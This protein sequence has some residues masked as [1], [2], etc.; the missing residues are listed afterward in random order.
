MD[1]GRPVKVIA[2]TNVLVRH[3]I[4]DDPDQAAVATA[5]LGEAQTVALPLVT[6]CEL[7]WVLRRAYKVPAP[8]VSIA[9]RAL[10]NASNVEADRAGVDAGLALLDAGGDFADGVIAYAGR[11]LGGDRF[12]SFDRAAVDLLAGQG[13]EAEVLGPRGGSRR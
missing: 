8:Q 4:G 11:M 1:W 2:D 5:L 7:V 6:L 10:V 9:V 13:I 3:V 12:V